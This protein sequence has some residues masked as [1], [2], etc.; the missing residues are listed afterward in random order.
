[1]LHFFVDIVFCRTWY[2]VEIPQFYNPVTSLLL[3]PEEKNLWRG[4]KTVGQLKRERGVHSEPQKDS[5]Y[6]VC[7]FHL[8]KFKT[9]GVCLFVQ[10]M[11]WFWIIVVGHKNG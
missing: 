4:M 3:A 9:T 6:T 5:L 2:G 1:M 11:G 7:I 8:W 10:A